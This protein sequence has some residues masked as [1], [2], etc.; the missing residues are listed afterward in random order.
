[1]SAATTAA[2]TMWIIEDE[3]RRKDPDYEPFLT[4]GDLMDNEWALWLICG[5]LIA[6]SAAMIYMSVT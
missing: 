1:M 6:W 2:L 3:R 5:I 4:V